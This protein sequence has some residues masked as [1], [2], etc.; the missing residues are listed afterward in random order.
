M[1]RLSSFRTMGGTFL[2]EREMQFLRLPMLFLE[3]CLKL[4]E[5]CQLCLLLYCVSRG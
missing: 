1:S 5:L 2:L 4:L 3:L